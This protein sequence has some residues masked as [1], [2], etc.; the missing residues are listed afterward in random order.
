[1]EVIS[2]TGNSLFL[3]GLVREAQNVRLA[4]LNLKVSQRGGSGLSRA[5][6]GDFRE[7]Q[8]SM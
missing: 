5:M 6:I 8:V 3:L 4:A 2:G 7:S 1:M